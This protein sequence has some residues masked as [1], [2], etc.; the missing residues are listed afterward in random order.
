MQQ[1]LYQLCLAYRRPSQKS[2]VFLIV[3]QNL[4]LYHAERLA[5]FRPGT[6]PGAL[7]FGKD[8]LPDD[9]P[10]SDERVSTQHKTNQRT[11]AT[12]LYSGGTHAE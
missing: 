10:P 12:R 11:Y 4:Y 3:S 2:P 8:E 6:A 5:I 9:N 7:P 1:C